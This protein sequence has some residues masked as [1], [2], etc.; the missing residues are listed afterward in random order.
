MVTVICS[1]CGQPIAEY[2]PTVLPSAFLTVIERYLK[3]AK[4]QHVGGRCP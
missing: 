1:R 3:S 4:V 2:D